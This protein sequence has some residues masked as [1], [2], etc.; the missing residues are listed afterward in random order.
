MKVGFDIEIIKEDFSTFEVPCVCV[1]SKMRLLC[2]M[3]AILALGATFEQ[4][5]KM[6]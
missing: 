4:K 2:I 3:G 6:P 1:V 5:G